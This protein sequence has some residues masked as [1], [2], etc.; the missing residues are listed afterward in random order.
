MCDT[1]SYFLFILSFVGRQKKVCKEKRLWYCYR[2]ILPIAGF[3]ACLDDKAV[4][5]HLRQA[6][7]S[8]A[9]IQRR[10]TSLYGCLLLWWQYNS[11]GQSLCSV[12]SA[13]V[14]NYHVGNR[15]I[16]EKMRKIGVRALKLPYCFEMSYWVQRT[17][18]KIINAIFYEFTNCGLNFIIWESHS[19]STPFA[20]IYKCV[21]TINRIF[22]IVTIPFYTWHDM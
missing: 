10:H 20:G 9:R 12:Y 18:K 8:C 22:I 6:A 7:L 21:N 15:I 16:H 5:C 1:S 13:W 11:W 3:L 17:Y 2:Y 14:H 19:N 4:T